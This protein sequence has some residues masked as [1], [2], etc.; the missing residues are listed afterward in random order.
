MITV[1]ATVF[2]LGVMIL[3]HELGHFWAA[4]R[5]GIRVLKFSFGFPPKLFGFRRGD[6]EYA[7]QA[8]PVGGYVEM[9]GETSFDK[10]ADPKP[11]DFMACPWWGRVLVSLAG[12][13]ANLATAVLIFFLVGMI[14]IKAPDYGPVV[15]TVA[16]GG[17]AEQAGVAPGDRIVSIGGFPVE[18]WH[19]A[20]LAWGRAEQGTS[21]RIALALERG[22]RVDTVRAMR[23][24]RSE[25]LGGMTPLVPARLGDIAPGYPA[26]Q[27]GLMKGDLV[28]SVDGQ[29]VRTWDEMRARIVT[30]IDQEVALIVLR[31]ADT[32]VVALRPVEQQTGQGRAGIIGITAP[33]HGSYVL[34]LGPA[35]AL[36]NGALSAGALAVRIYQT[37]FRLITKPSTAKQL[38]SILMIGQMAGESA[39]RGASDLFLLMA[40]L[41]VMLFVMN[42]LPLP[43]L[44]GGGIFFALLEGVRGRA[45]PARA[46]SAI[47]TFGVALLITVMALAVA[48]DG[49]RMLTRRAALK[50]SQPPAG[51]QR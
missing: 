41:S 40:S 1:L 18:S 46:Q 23:G 12:P 14:G 8:I 48:N 39:R 35:R 49:L 42:L 20:D 44:D 11:G 3:V 36:A 4:R 29:P 33:E 28:L 43:V 17:A 7:V 32:L 5:A 37:L 10:A 6:T 30:R 38:G 50:T 15:G 2:L 51:Q 16:A 24:S 9:A 13:A 21:D 47:H 26:Y 27:A 34:R 22:G 31:G 25:W 19:G 45:L